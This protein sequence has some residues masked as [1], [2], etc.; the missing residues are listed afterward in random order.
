MTK[1]FSLLLILVVLAGCGGNP[2]VTNTFRLAEKSFF[3]DSC[4]E[5]SCATIDFT[6]VEFVS[7]P[8]TDQMN[9]AIYEQVLT[10]AQLGDQSFSDLESSADFFIQEFE[11]LK[12]DFPDASG[13]WFVKLN[14]SELFDSLGIKTLVFQVESYTGGAHGNN[15]INTLNFDVANRRVLS[16]KELVI[17]ESKL[18]ELAE[19]S[20]RE[21]HEVEATQSLEEVGDFFLPESGFFLPETMGY[22]N[23]HF[24]LY[25]QPYEIGPYSLGSTELQ[26]PLEKLRGVVRQ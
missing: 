14:G 20:F 24:V 9:E 22:T 23:A 15:L 10:Y 6:W 21:Y 5:T 3:K 2:K 26:I 16:N 12:A 13:E 4:D 8:T 17:D 11:S 19:I 25:Y 7:D 1:S 18:L